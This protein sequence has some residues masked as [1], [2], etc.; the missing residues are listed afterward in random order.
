MINILRHVNFVISL[1]IG[2]TAMLPFCLVRPM[3]P[4]NN[5]VFFRT[6]KFLCHYLVGIT[7]H[8][9]GA[10]IIAQNRPNVFIGNHQHNLDV[11][12]V[13]GI[14]SKWSIVLGKFE[15]GLLPFFGQMYVLAG[16][17]LV[18][19][20]NKKKAMKSMAV[21]EEKIKNDRLSVLVFPEGTRNNQK[22]LLPFKKGA[23]YTA[24]RSGCPIIPFAA[25]QFAYYQDLNSFKRIHI[26]VKVFDPIPTEGKTTK[27]IPELMAHTRK[28]LEDGIAELNKN[29]NV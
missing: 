8:S 9:E 7:I 29:Y 15:L 21:I 18:K 13:S 23:Y 12:T 1:F 20:G 25:S 28:I 11:L 14:F 2:L 4:K 26:Y 6:F 22:E 3:S 5:V 19:R 24:I 16:N 17:I 10:E 27:D